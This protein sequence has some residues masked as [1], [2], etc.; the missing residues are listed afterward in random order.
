MGRVFSDSLNLV[1]N[2]E[3]RQAKK[4][5]YANSPDV[6]KKLSTPSPEDMKN[7]AKGG[8]LDLSVSESEFAEGI[9][10]DSNRPASPGG[11]G[12]PVIFEDE[13]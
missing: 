4:E 13:D 11:S 9:Q 2:H 1:R 10:V 6:E 7:L 12:D 8:D 3:T 5:A